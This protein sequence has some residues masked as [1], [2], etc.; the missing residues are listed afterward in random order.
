MNLPSIAS[1]RN[2]RA[3][4]PPTSSFKRENGR[5][6]V[7]LLNVQK[8]SDGFLCLLPESVTY[9]PP[10]AKDRDRSQQIEIAG[11]TVFVDFR[12]GMASIEI[13]GPR[14]VVGSA[15]LVWDKSAADSVWKQ[16]VADYPEA[17]SRHSRWIKSMWQ[18]PARLPWACITLSP[19]ILERDVNR[20]EIAMAS[21]LLICVS[22]SVMEQ[23]MHFEA[24]RAKVLSAQRQS[25]RNLGLAPKAGFSKVKTRISGEVKLQ[26][27]K[28]ARQ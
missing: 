25:A 21:A 7:R 4:K 15:R 9:A 14:Q 20:N 23:V 2:I 19:E 8:R 3:A 16:A 1:P 27:K 5:L 18:R 17:A 28:G 13:L 10:T 11:C 26:T 6:Q 24:A 12:P 22:Q